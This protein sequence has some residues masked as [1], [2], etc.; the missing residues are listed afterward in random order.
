MTT[1]V[2]RRWWAL[3]AVCFGLFMALLDVTIVNVA[4]PKIQASFGESISSLEWILNAY[5]LVFA[6][7]LVPVSRLGDIYGR[8]RVFALGLAVFSLGSLLC[9]L[10]GRISVLGLSHA[11]TLN[12]FRGL[13]GVGSAA[14]L[15]LSL[16]IIS[17]TFEGNER[18]TAIGIWGGVTALATAIGPLVG[19]YLVT[20]FGWEAVFYPNVPIG[21]IGIALALWAIR[22]SRDESAPHSV[23]IF[24][25][26]TITVAIFSLVL[27]LIEGNALGWTSARILLLFASF[28]VF[29]AA[30]VIGELRLEHPMVDP[31]L[32][33][34]PAF[35]GS[36]AVVFTLGAGF[37]ALLFILTIYLQDFLGLTALQAGLRLLPLTAVVVV[38]APVAG[39]LTGRFGP[40]PPMLVAM[41][42]LAAADVWMSRVSYSNAPSSWLVL[43]PAFI[44]GGLGTGL[45]TPPASSLAVGTV[46]PNRVGMGS[47]VN[48]IARQ[49]GI[50]FGVAF[51]G[52]ILNA[53]Y[54]AATK[55]GIAALT[56]LSPTARA[57]ISA[58]V[59]KAGVMAGATGLAHAGPATAGQPLPPA[60]QGI[61]RHAFI[62]GTRE[63][64]LIAALLL[65]LGLIACHVLVGNT[66]SRTL[67]AE[68]EQAAP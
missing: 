16:A 44:M 49:L 22:E 54:D 65:A 50:A 59:R 66:V 12:I 6:V 25:F 26:A 40:R 31:R 42:L 52:A 17:A 30:F 57:A 34:I 32:F 8:K 68:P 9:A 60:V 29:L 38:S 47:G 7:L 15:P 5:T 28:V 4:L 62:T 58:G 36:S 1:T 3:I 35:T 18:N 20:H 19:G 55:A 24:G 46:P 64:F 67:R 45:V 37:Y 51:F 43:L 41:A 10:S 2:N 48:N 56:S 53:R 23:D 39:R 11:A 14:M 33:R 63:V 61:A 27:A 21:M 13:Q